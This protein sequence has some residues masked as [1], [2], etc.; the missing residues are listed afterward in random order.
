[1][2]CNITSFTKIIFRVPSTLLAWTVVHMAWLGF[3][4]RTALLSVWVTHVKTSSAWNHKKTH[5]YCSIISVTIQPQICFLIL[6]KINQRS[7]LP[8]YGRFL[9]LHILC[10]YGSCHHCSIYSTPYQSCHVSDP[11]YIVYVC[12]EI[13]DTCKNFVPNLMSLLTL[14]VLAL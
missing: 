11:W 7:I 3:Y 14:W 2:G 12:I 5:F 8:Q 9:L 6:I 4:L 1:M 10:A 13:V